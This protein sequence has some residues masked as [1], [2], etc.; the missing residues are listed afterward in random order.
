MSRMIFVNLPVLDLA[1]SMTFH[2][3][4]GARNEPRF[5][6]QSAAM[7]V[8]SDTI[9]IMLLT[10]DRFRDFTPKAIADAHAVSE[11]LLALSADSRAQVDE[12]IDKA[13]EAGGRA[14]PCPTQDY[15]FMYGR[16]YEDLD[17][18]IFEVVWMDM[19]AMDREDS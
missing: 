14:D 15:G 5:T 19:S 13:V 6:D 18:H 7:M 11:V 10:H 2:E 4:L 9:S 16:S 12:T 1:R 3:A 17:G 8:I